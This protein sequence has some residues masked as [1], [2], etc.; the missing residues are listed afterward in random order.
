MSETFEKSQMS[1]FF[2]V[3][4]GCIQSK[5]VALNALIIDGCLVSMVLV[6]RLLV[7]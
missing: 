4:S 1:E 3:S 5:D 7:G 2:D 6:D